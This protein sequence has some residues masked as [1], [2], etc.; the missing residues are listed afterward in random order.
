MKRFLLTLCFLLFAFSVFA[1]DWGLQLNETFGLKDGDTNSQNNALSYSGTL[2]PW[3]STPLGSADNRFYFSA[4][5]TA[6]YNHPLTSDDSKSKVLFIPEILRT[7]FTFRTKS[8][9]EIKLG[10]MLYF[11]PLGFIA[12]GLF[13]GA[14]VL[15]SLDNSTLGVGLWHTGWLYKKNANI[16]MTGDELA[17]Y[18]DNDTYFA[19]CRLVA[20]IDYENPYLAPWLRL[21]ASLI[22]QFDLS[23][24][25]NFYHKQ[26][27]AVK[28]N[29]PVNNFMFD[30]GAVFGLAQDSTE[31]TDYQISFAGE[32]GIG[33][34][35]PTSITDLLR[36]TCRLTSGKVENSSIAAFVPI[37]TVSHGDVLSARL[38]A[39]SMI[40]L[41][42]TARLH[43][44][45]S[46]NL[47]SSY[48]ILSDSGTYKD[49]P[50]NPSEKNENFF[51]G[52]E[53]SSRF[54]W[55]PFSDLQ[56]NLGGGIFMPS[57]GNVNPKST[58]LWRLDLNVILSIF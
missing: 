49:F 51:L 28:T 39:L 4:G 16:T 22:G 52:N 8:D 58:N 19:P 34:A 13:D 3:F 14:R 37:T 21:K 17:L 25:D 26:Y 32:L 30:L 56:F 18:H 43:E 7:E 36:L 55:A 20:A 2:L 33:W 50:M 45:F 5:I 35:L 46:L 47:S 40:R 23:D 41:D 6:E 48:F 53:F 44:T 27:L 9:N 29:I 38:S 11:D 42:Y 12:N 15:F 24:G 57:L 10:R 54:V 31:E 1:Y